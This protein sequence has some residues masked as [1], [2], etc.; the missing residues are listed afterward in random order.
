MRE[1]LIRHHK[2]IHRK[3]TQ[4][5]KR[6]T[7]VVLSAPSEC[8]DSS[9]EVDGCLSGVME[10]RMDYAIHAEED[11]GKARNEIMPAKTWNHAEPSNMST[12]LV[13]RPTSDAGPASAA[14][15]LHDPT[16]QP[17]CANCDSKRQS[18]ADCSLISCVPDWPRRQRGH[19]R[20]AAQTLTS[21]TAPG[22]LSTIP[23]INH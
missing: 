11:N 12:D 6:L 15:A 17:L 14:Q 18:A 2:A 9:L 22:H 19:G 23:C 3:K 1:Q 13:S 4:K 21:S 20:A 10:I 7:G 16:C 8:L 5:S